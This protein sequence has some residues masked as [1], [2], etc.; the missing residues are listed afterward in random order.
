MSTLCTTSSRAAQEASLSSI[1]KITRTPRRPRSALTGWSSTD[2]GFEWISLSPN[3]PT[4]RLL[5]S[6]WDDPHTAAVHRGVSRGTTTGATKEAT[7]EVTNVTMIGMKTGSTDHT[8]A[9]PH[10]LTTAEDTALDHDHDHTHHVTT[11]L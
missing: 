9:D 8:D 6:T 1:L 7:T 11:E 10:L 5:G 3:G 2:A 4:P